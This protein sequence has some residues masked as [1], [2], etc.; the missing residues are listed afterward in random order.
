MPVMVTTYSGRRRIRTAANKAARHVDITHCVTSCNGQHGQS[1]NRSWPLIALAVH[2]ARETRGAPL[3]GEAQ[4]ARN[5]GYDRDASNGSGKSAGSARSGRLSRPKCH[6]FT[7]RP[8]R[9]YGGTDEF[10][11][12][13]RPARRILRQPCGRHVCLP[14][15]PSSCGKR[16]IGRSCVPGADRRTETAPPPCR[17]SAGAR[18]RSSARCSRYWPIPRC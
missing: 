10:D 13:K 16:P 7:N 14:S 17:P 1:M 15:I 3:V 5:Y 11:Y 4:L 9:V 2:P 12:R 18:H 8:N 6:G